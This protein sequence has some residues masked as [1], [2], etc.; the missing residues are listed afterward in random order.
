MDS[1]FGIVFAFNL[2]N[3]DIMLR[4]DFL[5]S[6]ILGIAGAMIP[7]NTSK[8]ASTINLNKNLMPDTVP[9]G[10]IAES[11]IYGKDERLERA[12]GR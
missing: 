8:A 3:C 5:W 9:V 7:K 12:L 2:L 10:F 1:F 6:S 11:G 4:K